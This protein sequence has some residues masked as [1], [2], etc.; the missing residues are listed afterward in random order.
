MVRRKW[1]GGAGGSLQCRL[2][3]G[4]LLFSVCL[5]LGAPGAR[6]RSDLPPPSESSWL[7]AP[8]FAARARGVAP[9]DSL[10]VED[11]PLAEEATDPRTAGLPRTKNLELERFR[12]FSP[13]A[14]I[15]VQTR[16]GPKL[17]APPST[18]HFR[19]RIEGDDASLA[20][21]S[22]AE[23][24]SVRGF[25]ADRDRLWALASDRPGDAP[26][27]AEMDANSPLADGPA[28]W[29]CGQE[30]LPAPPI[31]AAA[32]AAQQLL[33]DLARAASDQTYN[34]RIAIETDFE[35]WDLFGSTPA[36]TDYVS[37][38]IAAISAIYLRDINTTLEVAYLSLWPNGPSTDP[39]TVVSSTG[40]ALTEFRNYWNANRTNVS[41]SVAHMLSGKPLGGGIAYL[42]VLCSQTFGYGVTGS[43]EGEFSTTQPWL[44]WD[45]LAVSHELGHNFGSSH[46]HCYSP[47]VDTCYNA[48]TGC[49]SG[50]ET[51]VPSNGGGS[52]MSYCHLK[53]GGYAN[54]NFWLGRAGFYGTQSDRVA[55]VMRNHVESHTSCLN[56]AGPPGV[57]ISATPTTITTGSSS[58]LNWNA[59]GA[60]SC[61]GSGGWSGAKATSGSQSVSPGSN[62]TYTLNCTGPGGQSGASATVTVTAP[63]TVNLTV[64]SAS[65]A[66]GA[67]TSLSW[68]SS[69]VTSCTASGAWSGNRNLTGSTSVQPGGTMTYSLT[70]TGAGGS[71]SDSETVQVVLPDPGILVADFDSG[72]EGFT[73]EGSWAR[74]GED[75]HGAGQAWSDSPGGSY[76]GS[77]SATLWSPAFDLSR[78]GTATAT[79]WHRFDFQSN[80]DFGEVWVDDGED[81]YLLRS[82]TGGSGGWVQVSIDLSEFA[83]RASVTLG[84]RV[85]TDASGASDGWHVDDVEITGE[86]TGTVFHPVTPCR[87]VDTRDEQGAYGGQSIPG[88][89]DRF[90]AIT[91]SCGIPATARAVAVNLTVV[92]PSM[93]GHLRIFPAD[94]ARP[95]SSAVNFQAG[96]VRAN[97]ALLRL[98]MDGLG[99]VGV[100]NGSPGIAH[101]IIDVTGYFD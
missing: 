91:G 52:I 51:A 8:D 37:D 28:P 44:F 43:L 99:D 66:R 76:A 101:V 89:T 54:Q 11:V 40:S 30:A 36:A 6:A 46:T 75:A 96:M 47:P 62:T 4:V 85:S 93:S 88:T 57:S 70:C 20:V 35:F 67:S 80:Q 60:T 56:S 53:S 65:I 86:E 42:G 39:W 25:V 17:V 50:A 77:T 84:F 73:G 59:T 2:A 16:R 34:A 41:R 68:T 74:S 12:V 69:N 100:Y 3:A 45:L 97:N 63:P 79:F 7:F 14:Q 1:W 71:A 27:V 10:L 78:Y 21:L 22:V 55:T 81:L 33:P 38:L 32:A 5:V 48:E 72:A 94:V 24:G 15:V 29:S 49:Y 18:A 92:T 83:G 95:T 9:G 64:G 87:A 23:D 19:G 98:P 31:P 61:T 58:T 26:K 82:F 90:F 13:D